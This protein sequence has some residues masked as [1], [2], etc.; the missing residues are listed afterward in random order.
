MP[1]GSGHSA[2]AD[3]APIMESSSMLVL[4]MISSSAGGEASRTSE[5]DSFGRLC[6]EV[7]LSSRL[8]RIATRERTILEL[9][10]VL[11][12]AGARKRSESAPPP[13]EPGPASPAKSDASV[14]D[15]DGLRR[16][17]R[18]PQAKQQAAPRPG[19]PEFIAME[20][21]RLESIQAAEAGEV[22]ARSGSRAGWRMRGPLARLHRLRLA[23]A[24]EPAYSWEEAVG[25]ENESEA[26]GAERAR[27]G[28]PALPSLE[29]RGRGAGESVRQRAA[30]A[31]FVELLRSVTAQG[32]RWRMACREDEMEADG[33]SGGAGPLPSSR[34]P[35]PPPDSD[36]SDGEESSLASAIA[37]AR[38][39]AEDA[40]ACRGESARDELLLESGSSI[41]LASILGAEE[42]RE[43]G[44]ERERELDE[45]R[46]LLDSALRERDKAAERAEEAE[47][48]GR[49]ARARAAEA[50]Q[51]ER[52]ARA[53][54]EWFRSERDAARAQLEALKK[55]RT[56]AAASPAP[57]RAESSPGRG[58]SP[59]ADRVRPGWCTCAPHGGLPRT[60]G[61]GA[62]EG[63]P[64]PMPPAP[65]V[66]RLEPLALV[67]AS[68]PLPPA[69]ARLEPSTPG[70][71]APSGPS[72]PEHEPG[73]PLS[74]RTA[75]LAVVDLSAP[76][77]EL[78]RLAVSSPR[79]A[80]PPPELL[81]YRHEGS[82][83]RPS[84][85]SPFTVARLF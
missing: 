38:R 16:R 2:C 69:A 44:R 14:S 29:M 70:R 11:R 12:E 73:S 45:L 57:S 61:A 76:T 37:E 1:D 46:R 63:S 60:P 59:P 6:E 10:K 83:S 21:R 55:E 20:I 4:D 77:M 49:G 81:G 42:A 7:H 82:P 34:R 51:R 85:D 80:R 50:E 65:L 54:A 68:P 39:R 64:L 47:R 18:R 27:A 67:R 17:R 33:A 79:G 62:L 22:L 25:K 52:E 30:D 72:P 71:G 9:S 78:L 5:L 41:V 19:S 66:P 23:I 24:E 75:A 35:A 36:G 48:A 56:A 84:S 13:A 31:F 28:A 74:P 8:L 43:K 15:D 26:G 58:E 40:L 53:T 32:R 3:G